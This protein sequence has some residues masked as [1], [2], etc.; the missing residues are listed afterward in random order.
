[1]VI[2]DFYFQFPVYHLGKP[3]FSVVQDH[4]PVFTE[5]IHAE[6]WQDGN[7]IMKI[8]NLDQLSHLADVYAPHVQ[9]I[10]FDP[11]IV[12]KRWTAK[13]FVKWHDVKTAILRERSNPGT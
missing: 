2:G 5:L 4:I 13:V 1:M 6:T 9:G 12:N 10:C 8:D 3:H 11:V 7:T